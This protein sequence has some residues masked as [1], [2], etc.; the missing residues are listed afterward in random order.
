[1][2]RCA[3]LFL[4][5]ASSSLAFAQVKLPNIFGDSMVLQRDRPIPVWGTA[6]ANEKVAVQFNQQT[7]TTK[8]GKDGKWQLMLDAEAAG[9]PYTLTVTGAA[10]RAAITACLPGMYG[11]PRGKAI[12]SLR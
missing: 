7:K 10:T 11:R 1:M 4:M 9:G 12:W 6:A 2:K 5:A 3:F 8:A